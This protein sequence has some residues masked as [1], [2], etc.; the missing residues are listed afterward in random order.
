MRNS[1]TDGGKRFAIRWIADDTNA[2][3]A[4]YG[5]H[6]YCG[7]GKC[8]QVFSDTDL[9]MNAS[10]MIPDDHV[11]VVMSKYG[12][13]ERWQSVLE[14]FQKRHVPVLLIAGGR[15][16]EAWPADFVICTPFCQRHDLADEMD[17]YV[18]AKYVIDLLFWALF[19]DH[20]EE[21]RFTQSLREAIFFGTGYRKGAVNH[22]NSDIVCHHRA[23][24]YLC[25]FL[26]NKMKKR[27]NKDAV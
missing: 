24:P 22:T 12:L 3:L 1:L 11:V 17:Y 23:V 16:P 9:Q 2:A 4:Q 6:L 15:K 27:R 18:A 20:K 8:G 13:K 5:M 21:A 19:E 25:F 10:L 7:A 26:F 14:H